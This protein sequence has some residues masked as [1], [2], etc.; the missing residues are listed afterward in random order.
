MTTE[1]Y[2]LVMR[3]DVRDIFNT[4]QQIVRI[5]DFDIS[6]FQLI[7]REISD[8]S[9]AVDAL[10]SGT[11]PDGDYGDIKVSG[12]GTA[13][14]IDNDAVSNAKL[15]E[16]AANTIKVNNTGSTANPTD[17][18]ISAQKLV[19]RGASGNITEIT[20]GV[21]LSFAGDT[22]NAAAPLYTNVILGSTFTTA[23]T[24]PQNV[25]G[26][27]FTPAANKTYLVEIY[28]LLT[29][30][31]ASTAPRF[32]IIWPSNMTDGGGLFDTLGIA[33][34]GQTAS[35]YVSG[36]TSLSGAGTGSTTLTMPAIVKYRMITG[37]SVSG[38]FQV[39]LQAEASGG[40]TVGINAGSFLRYCEIS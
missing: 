19:G 35:N 13:M 14:T 2:P 20:P 3:E 32:G 24:T 38:D 21:G 30:T 7:K 33:S 10:T 18:A 1:R 12:T 28:Y 15:A 40:G 26:F 6:D 31:V 37:A 22:L 9:N 25:T 36:G 5:R 29:T 17:L 8:L 23:L 27:S 4:L 11:I 39:V 34:G 16:M